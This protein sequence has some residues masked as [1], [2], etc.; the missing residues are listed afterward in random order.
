MKIN[1][2]SKL[3]ILLITTT[4]VSGCDSFV[5]SLSQSVSPDSSSLSSNES[6]QEQSSSQSASSNNSS[7]SSEEAVQPVIPPSYGVNPILKDYTLQN[8]PTTCDYHQPK[9]EIVWKASI[10]SKGV[11]RFKCY[12]CGGFSEEYYYDL[13]EVAFVNKT[14]AL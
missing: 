6:S 13:D 4:L 11:K 9:E 2:F 5:N 7:S 8:N 12:N 14:F 3:I 10:V 1:C